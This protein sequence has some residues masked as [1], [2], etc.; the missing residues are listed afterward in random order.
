MARCDYQLSAFTAHRYQSVGEGE[1]PW[2]QQAKDGISD[3]RDAIF[4]VQYPFVIGG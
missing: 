4:L 1:K 3:S 2:N